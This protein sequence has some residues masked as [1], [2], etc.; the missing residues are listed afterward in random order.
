MKI[1][2]VD[3]DQDLLALVGFALTQAGY[4]VV[5]AADVPAALQVFE[6]VVR[7]VAQA[8]GSPVRA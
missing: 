5:K 6:G 2:I 7:R 1:L 3:D 8:A 4:A